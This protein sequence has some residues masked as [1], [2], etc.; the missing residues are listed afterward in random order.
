M[1]I[2]DLHDHFLFNWSFTNAKHKLILTDSLIQICI[3]W[4]L[5]GPDNYLNDS[6]RLVVILRQ[7]IVWI[8]TGMEIHDSL[9]SA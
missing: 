4:Y 2:H 5:T 8:G 7:A 9:N 1:I 3:Y 6:Y